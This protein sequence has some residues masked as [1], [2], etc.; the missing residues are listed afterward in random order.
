M[1]RST[2][3]ALVAAALLLATG[4]VGGPACHAVHP[5][6]PPPVIDCY[7]P[8]WGGLRGWGFFFGQAGY[9]AYTVNSPPY[10]FNTCGFPPLSESSYYPYY[11]TGINQYPRSFQY[12]W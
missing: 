10:R 2:R 8:Y 11:G 1:R 6:G 4:A 9:P 3:Y 7:R 5:P 12:N